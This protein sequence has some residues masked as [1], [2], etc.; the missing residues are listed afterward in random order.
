MNAEFENYLRKNLVYPELQK[1]WAST[2]SQSEMEDYIRHHKK[3][4]D[5]PDIDI[6]EAVK[7]QF[8]DL[9][10]LIVLRMGLVN[11]K[12]N[13]LQRFIAG[14][15]IPFLLKLLDAYLETSV[16][17]Q[18]ACALFEILHCCK[19]T[20][21]K[22]EGIKEFLGSS[23]S[24]TAVAKCLIY[25]FKPLSLL[26][27]DV[28]AV[29]C[30]WEDSTSKV[31]KGL[32]ERGRQYNEEPFEHL[33]KGLSAENMEITS[34]VM[35]LIVRLFTDPMDSYCRKLVKL[36]LN[37][38]TIKNKCDDIIHRLNSSSEKYSSKSGKSGHKTHQAPQVTNPKLSLFTPYMLK[39]LFVHKEVIFTHMFEL[40]PSQIIQYKQSNEAVSTADSVL[41]KFYKIAD[42]E[43][44]RVPNYSPYSETNFLVEITFQAKNAT[45]END[46]P[47][48]HMSLTGGQ[49]FQQDP[50]TLV[51]GFERSNDQLQWYNAIHYY[52][53][54]LKVP[55]EGY[56]FYKKY[57]FQSSAHKALLQDSSNETMEDHMFYIYCINS[58]RSLYDSF[59]E[60]LQYEKSKSNEAFQ[61]DLNNIDEL[62][63][64]LYEELLVIDHE[65]Y[66]LNLLQNCL[67]FS[68][69]STEK[70]KLNEKGWVHLVELSNRLVDVMKVDKK[71]NDETTSNKSSSALPQN[72]EEV[73]DSL[74]PLP[75]LDDIAEKIKLTGGRRKTLGDEHSE[76]NDESEEGVD[77]ET[78]YKQINKLAKL[79]VMQKQEISSLRKQLQEKSVLGGLGGA[80]GSQD[81]L[82][83][84]R[85]KARRGIEENPSLKMPVTVIPPVNAKIAELLD[86]EPSPGCSEKEDSGGR[87]RSFNEPLPTPS[88]SNANIPRRN[89]FSFYKSQNAESEKNG[90][91]SS[92]SNRMSFAHLSIEDVDKYMKLKNTLPDA[93]LRQRMAAD[94]FSE[95]Q[96]NSFFAGAATASRSKKE[97]TSIFTKAANIG[98][99]LKKMMGGEKKEKHAS[100][101]GVSSKGSKKL[102]N[103]SSSRRDDMIN[104]IPSKKILSSS[105]PNSRPMS[106]ESSAANSK[107]MENN[108]AEVK[109][110]LTS[111]EEPKFSEKKSLQSIQETEESKETRTASLPPPIDEGSSAAVL[112]SSKTAVV[113]TPDVKTE[114]APPAKDPKFEKYEK[115]KKMNLPE[116]SVRHKM[117]MDNIPDHEIDAFFAGGSVVVSTKVN[118]EG[119][120]V[121]KKAAPPALDPK[122]EK[123]DQMRK[124]K[125]PEG[126]IRQKMAMEKLTPTE[127]ELFFN[128]Q[129]T[130][131]P[132]GAHAVTKKPPLPKRPVDTGPRFKPLHWQ[133][134]VL[135]SDQLK[136]TIFDEYS[137][138]KLATLPDMNKTELRLLTSM[139]VDLNTIKNGKEVLKN[140]ESSQLLEESKNQADP[141]NDK[142][143]EVTLL[144]A[145]GDLNIAVAVNKLPEKRLFLESMIECN[146]RVTKDDLDRLI[147]VLPEP[148]VVAKILSYP[149]YSELDKMNQFL[150]SCYD[151][152][153]FFQERCLVLQSMYNYHENMTNFKQLLYLYNAAYSDVLSIMPELKEIFLII[154]KIGNFLE[155]GKPLLP[156]GT[157][158]AAAGKGASEKKA[159]TPGGE[160]SSANNNLPT[161]V[162]LENPKTTN[163]GITFSAIS[164]CYSLRSNKSNTDTLLHFILL[165]IANHYPKEIKKDP[166]TPG[167]AK[168]NGAVPEFT[169]TQLLD[170]F[171]SQSN[172][173]ATAIDPFDKI[174][175]VFNHMKREF[176][177]LEKD[178][179]VV[180]K[181]KEENLTKL[182]TLPSPVPAAT[183]P[184]VRSHAGGSVPPST[185]HG[186]S[187]KP[188]HVDI[189]KL[190]LY[191]I[192]YDYLIEK[193]EKFLATNKA[194]YDQSTIECKGLYEKYDSLLEKFGEKNIQ[195]DGDDFDDQ[196]SVKFNEK[197]TTASPTGSNPAA[198]VSSHNLLAGGSSASKSTKGGEL[199]IKKF[200]AKFVKFIEH[201]ELARAD[202]KNNLKILQAELRKMDSTQHD[203]EEE[204]PTNWRASVRASVNMRSSMRGLGTDENAN[205]GQQQPQPQQQQKETETAGPTLQKHASG[206]E[207]LLNKENEKRDLSNRPSEEGEENK[208]HPTELDHTNSGGAVNQYY[209]NAQR[210]RS[211]T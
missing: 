210:N 76:V 31:V 29:C 167:G 104:T 57:L 40:T 85:S 121:D 199:K 135:K 42:I 109:K 18:V 168:E 27:L 46:K 173:R 32:E 209:Q 110:M 19:L 183:A 150:H 177:K 24:T 5:L 178:L 191:D 159:I 65:N 69:L 91:V 174:M 132:A 56:F 157:A 164:K 179:V 4:L 207:D 71:V 62:Y 97:R 202:N 84:M 146:S 117:K 102:S 28:L 54:L 203:E 34:A 96:I 204:V 116:G 10:N 134:L 166:L 187:K 106:K 15:G 156:P 99:I 55:E 87:K 50:R 190:R 143:K 151:S 1:I 155:S 68:M 170:V 3:Y 52:R 115:M 211:T 186:E 13:Y 139:F 152:I 145:K 26:A 25:E 9:S 185:K 154:L 66:F 43:N 2:F 41:D 138:K 125:I 59:C 7:L 36:K 182:N 153:P 51:L 198:S 30:F 73:F 160:P 107:K 129:G 188:T 165:F 33:Y 114:A 63:D 124:K 205:P 58:F 14:G 126:A 37:K 21:D 163:F 105:Q 11:D 20:L 83:T 208:P 161:P 98:S 12:D 136:N 192:A 64:K 175:M 67:S 131:A 60:I 89:S 142:K 38:N 172:L 79:S 197:E 184:S 196:T 16:T 44:M 180:K 119:E 72:T 123:Y 162:A 149:H 127:I 176:S 206:V 148:D 39:V 88:K 49:T 86:K 112:E 130:G 122:Y 200:L 22:S 61:F 70:K 133:K 147:S 95:N 78:L 103:R 90:A 35:E 120:Q 194:F 81:S 193:V 189:R 169:S 158:G 53:N 92:K 45:Y 94:G 113:E 128:P 80:G 144:D 47:S 201:Y 6:N 118:E 17:E 111:E 8:M 82:T 75:P 93:A 100:Q 74:V 141:A 108:T 137:K 101:P 48:K 77:K 23:R 171:E 195:E 140:L 181:R